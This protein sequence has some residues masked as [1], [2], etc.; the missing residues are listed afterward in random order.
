MAF[1]STAIVAAAVAAGPPAHSVTAVLSRGPALPA[2]VLPSNHQT[3]PPLSS[4]AG[5]AAAAAARGATIHDILLPLSLSLLGTHAHL[6]TVE[7]VRVRAHGDAA[8][9]ADPTGGG[10]SP[11]LSPSVSSSQ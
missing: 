7:A 11:R 2:A 4:H 5:V 3:S 9:A 10:N 1:P 6:A 8:A